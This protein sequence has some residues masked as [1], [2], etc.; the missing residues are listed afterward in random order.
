MFGEVNARGILLDQEKL[1]Y[2]IAAKTAPRSSRKLTYKMWLKFFDA[3]EGASLSCNRGFSRVQVVVVC[4]IEWTRRQVKPL[5]LSL[6]FLT[7]KSVH[8][9]CPHFTEVP[10]RMNQLETLFER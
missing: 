7:I 8:L 10:C 5:C 1:K 9:H 4:T 2:L 3:D 6:A